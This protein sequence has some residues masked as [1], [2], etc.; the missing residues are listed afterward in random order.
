RDLQNDQEASLDLTVRIAKP[1]YIGRSRFIFTVSASDQKN[2]GPQVLIQW[3]ISGARAKQIVEFYTQRFVRGT[4]FIA[5][6][7]WQQD[8]LG[9]YCLKV[10][11]PDELEIVSEPTAGA[12]GSATQ[13]LSTEAAVDPSLSAIHVGRC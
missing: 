7:K 9:T 1:R 12:T 10:N 6:G 8:K 2:T 3:F 5:F 11:K 13:D 4:R